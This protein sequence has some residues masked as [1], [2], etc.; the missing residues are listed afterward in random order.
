MAQTSFRSFS[1]AVSAVQSVFHTFIIMKAVFELQVFYFE[2]LS[3]VV[4]NHK[5]IR[6]F[7]GNSVSNV[8]DE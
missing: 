4:V 2:G 3:G 7:L 8:W 1:P 5:M 6:M